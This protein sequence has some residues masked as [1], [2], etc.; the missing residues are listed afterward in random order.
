M[1]FVSKKHIEESLAYFDEHCHPALMSLLAMMRE[2]LPASAD[3][4]DAAPFGAPFEKRLMGDFFGLLGAPEDRPYYIPF[5]PDAG[6]S[7]WR[8]AGYAGSSLQ[9]QRQDR[10]NIFRQHTTDRKK[11]ALQP[12]FV[13]TI[14][15]EPVH[16]IGDAPIL[17]AHLGAWAFRD[18]EISSINDVVQK[19]RSEFNLDQY[20]DIDDLFSEEIPQKFAAIPLAEKPIA[21]DELLSLLQSYEAD[22]ANA[23]SKL[24]TAKAAPSDWAITTKDLGDLGGLRGVEEAAARALAA[25]RSGMHI[26]FTGPPGTGK[27]TL[28]ESICA[29]AGFPSW[30]VPATDQWTTF[31][32]IGG[33]FPMPDGE[34]TADRLDFLPGAVV[35]AIQTGR[36]LIIDEINRADIDKAFG[37]LFTLLTGNSVTLPYRRRGE[38]GQ[39]RRVRLQAG[40]ALVDDAEIDS[41]P[42]PDWWRIVGSMNDADKASLKRLSMAF[43]RRFAFIPVPLPTP[44]IYEEIIRDCDRSKHTQMPALIETLVDLFADEAAGLGA[45]GI[46][47]GPGF[48]KAMLAQASAEWDIDPSRPLPSVWRSIIEGYLFPQLQGRAESHQALLDLV[49]PLIRNSDVVS[50]SSQLAVWTGFIDE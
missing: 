19:A 35:D 9:R 27:T 1:P 44:A 37:E 15:E 17:L 13:K 25:L 31:E 21:N 18:N 26:V 43:V 36:C 16:V 4:N 33:Y 40:S 49:S 10:G 23:K 42:V 3:D 32:T 8:G 2:G 48:P 6:K 7:R 34:G 45:I 29:S 24:V 30:T 12:N 46:P 20:A 38:D 28:A 11:W 41:I 14:L 39:F 47:L 5:G 50:F 22:E